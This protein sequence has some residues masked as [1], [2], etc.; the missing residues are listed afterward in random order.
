MNIAGKAGLTF[1]VIALKSVREMFDEGMSIP[2]IRRHVDSNI[3]AM[4]KAIK[5]GA[6]N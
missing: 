1:A 5:D 2:D 4:Q 3:R 6:E